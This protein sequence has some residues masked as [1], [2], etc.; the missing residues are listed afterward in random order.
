MLL[1]LMV[2]YAHSDEVQ[3]L[4]TM[5]IVCLNIISENGG[6][7]LYEPEDFPTFSPE[8]IQQRI[9]GSKIVIVSEQVGRISCP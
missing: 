4:Y 7:N 1:S 6:S 8:N 5:L 9:K 2:S 3:G